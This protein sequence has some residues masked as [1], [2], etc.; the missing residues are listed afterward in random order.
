MSMLTIST[1]YEVSSPW[2]ASLQAVPRAFCYM[3]ALGLAVTACGTSGPGFQQ[4]KE[5]A[6]GDDGGASDAPSA[7][8]VLILGDGGS[9]DGE[10]GQNAEVFGESPDTLY[11]LDP[12]TKTVSIVGA[13][14]GCNQV[15]DIALDK[16][17]NMYA[18]TVDGLYKI[19]RKTA[20]CTLIAKGNYPNSLSFVPAGT[21]DPK[22]EA[23]VGY[24]G[25]RY[26]RIDPMSGAVT[27]I[28]SIGQGYSSSGDIV[29][30]KGG[31]TYLTVKAGPN[32]NCSDCLI[33]VDPAT[34]AFLNEWGP[35]EHTDVFGLAFWAG[36]VYGFDNSGNL[37]EVDFHGL[38]M[39]IT[40][41]PVPIAD[42]GMDAG[43]PQF[44]GAGS[45]TSAPPTPTK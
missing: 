26:T 5:D 38:A 28:N 24:V 37:F 18:T 25:D 36:A 16:D 31:G 7:G 10:Q 45:T 9:V 21:L 41:I 44:F 35:V 39:Q 29:S 14:Q 20:A 4:A 1:E 3:A 32:G 13:F 17:S 12:T 22:V 11:R 6:G 40:G 8:D 19:D 2:A 43:P 27:P 15:T 30:V 34:G 23:L 33:Q 42:A